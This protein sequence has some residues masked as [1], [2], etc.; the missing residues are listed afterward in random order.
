MKRR[1]FLGAAAALAAPLSAAIP[2]GTPAA[3][4]FNRCGLTPA[5]FKKRW[6][7]TGGEAAWLYEPGAEIEPF[8]DWY[9]GDREVKAWAM[10]V[11][12]EQELNSVQ[13]RSFRA[14][15][16]RRGKRCEVVFS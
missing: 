5:E 10:R 15:A 8:L 2:A 16:E 12:S 7:E 9:P 1:A 4:G 3:V 11:S 13:A 6:A 14:E